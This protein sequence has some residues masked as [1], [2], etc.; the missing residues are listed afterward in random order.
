MGCLLWRAQKLGCGDGVTRHFL[1]MLTELNMRVLG[2]SGR[3]DLL[4]ERGWLGREGEGQGGEGGLLQST[5]AV[6]PAA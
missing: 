2:A 5:A 3:K 6:R 4:E 1:D